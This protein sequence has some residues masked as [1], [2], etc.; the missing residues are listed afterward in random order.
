MLLLFGRLTEYNGTRH[1]RVIIQISRTVVHNDHIA[2]LH[3]ALARL[4]VWIGAVGT[5]GHN[6]VKRKCIRTVRKHVILKFGANLLFGKTRLDVV[7]HVQKRLIGNALSMTHELNFGRIFDNP[8]I[9]DGTMHT[10]HQCRNAPIGKLS[11]KIIKKCQLNGILDSHHTGAGRCYMLCC[12]CRMANVVHINLP[13][14]IVTQAILKGAKVARIRM[15]IEFIGRNKRR[16][17]VLK[18]KRTLR[19]RQPPK[20]RVMPKNNRIIALLGHNLA[21]TGNPL[22]ANLCICHITSLLEND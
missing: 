20:I 11:L 15:Q 21:K 6:G 10:R 19:V 22:C 3:H 13:R 12:P 14:S 4:C 18:V 2:L 16:V 17:G 9:G 5:G 7:K 1:I 8:K